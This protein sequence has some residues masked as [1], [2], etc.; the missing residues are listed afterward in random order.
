MKRILLICFAILILISPLSSCK[1]EKKSYASI[2]RTLNTTSFDSG[3]VIKNVKLT[4]LSTISYYCEGLLTNN[5]KNTYYYIQ[6]KATFKDANGEIVA[7]NWTYTTL[8]EGLAPNDAVS[9]KVE[10]DYDP[11]IK[12]CSATVQDYEF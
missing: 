1:E 3:L 9:F 8:S 4:K 12:S 11:K 7:T 5:S 10:V 2:S 6:V